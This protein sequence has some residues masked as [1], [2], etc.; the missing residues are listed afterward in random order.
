[1]ARIQPAQRETSPP[2]TQA[3]LDQVQKK[4]GRVPNLVATMAASRP[5]AEAYLSFS[6]ALAT[7]KLPADLRERLALVVGEE[8]GCGYCLAAHSSLGKMAGLSKDEVACARRGEAD[9]PKAR[10]A[11][12]FARIVVRERGRVADSDVQ[13]LRE[14]GFDDGEIAEIT[15]HVALNLFTNYFNLVADT[16]VDFPAAPELAA[17]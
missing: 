1:M 4:M 13:Q 5:V 15:A 11:L 3:L 9:D 2:E 12:Q 17:A 10:A 16:E 14:A 8:N 6:G 7:G